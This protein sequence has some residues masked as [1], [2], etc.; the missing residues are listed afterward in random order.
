MFKVKFGASRAISRLIHNYS[1]TNAAI[2]LKLRGLTVRF[3][4][5]SYDP[6]ALYFI[7]FKRIYGVVPS[8]YSVVDIGAHIGTFSLYA[9]LT[10]ASQVLAFEPERNNFRLLTHNIDTNRLANR[11]KAFNLAVWSEDTKRTLFTSR[12]TA[13]HSFY[14]YAYHVGGIEPVTCKGINTILQPLKGP[15]FLKVDA[16][17]SEYEIITHIDDANIRKIARIELEYHVGSE[18]LKSLFPS[19]VRFLNS[20]AFRL[21][22]RKDSNVISA[23]KSAL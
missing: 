8:G 17:G 2:S 16:E 4:P 14:P 7:L 9:C 20:K 19:L 22:F 3:R 10:N 18:I 1:H 23:T 6:I 21:T 13:F 11:V 15:I 12:G 5:L